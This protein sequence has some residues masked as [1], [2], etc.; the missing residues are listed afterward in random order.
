[1]NNSPTTLGV[2]IRFANSESTLP[3]VLAA[4]QRQTRQPE[5]ILGVANNS[6]D[7]SRSLMESAGR[8]SPRLDR[9]L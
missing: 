1:M 8:A 4:L 7:S 3:V 6:T 9:A 5:V 2:L